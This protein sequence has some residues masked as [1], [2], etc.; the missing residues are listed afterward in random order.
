MIKFYQDITIYNLG[1]SIL[2]GLYTSFLWG[3]AIFCTVGMFI[4]LV[5]FE[6]FRKNQYYFYYNMG[7]TKKRLLIYTWLIN[8]LL[9]LPAFVIKLITLWLF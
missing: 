9:A 3:L 5:V 6:A 4:G 1:F 2:I 7:V 8:L